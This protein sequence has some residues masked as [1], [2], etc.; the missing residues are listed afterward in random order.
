[1]VLIKLLTTSA[2]SSEGI[3]NNMP[4][5]HDTPE[6]STHHDKD[7]CYKC[8]KCGAHGIKPIKHLA[9]QPL[10]LDKEYE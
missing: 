7:D 9:D 3:L 4:T 1:M 5:L 8:D 2:P 10:L 6:G